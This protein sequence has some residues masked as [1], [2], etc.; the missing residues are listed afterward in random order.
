MNHYEILFVVKPTL[1]DE[2]TR[3]QI[4]R[5]AA[6]ITEH[7]GEIVATDD[8]GMRRLAY[9]IEKHERGYYT[10]IYF[11]APGAL[12]AE[13]ERQMRYNEEI[14]KFM[15]VKYL[16]KKEV[17]QFKKLVTEAERKA[18]GP[19][20]STEPETPADETPAESTESATETAQTHEEKEV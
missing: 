1:T 16:K 6:I 10:V 20:A 11:K 15:T 12:I 5:A 9:P 4:E 19:D 13:L 7:G 14:L 2:E 18:K 3:T 8:M 17:T